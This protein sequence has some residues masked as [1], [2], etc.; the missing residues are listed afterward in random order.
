MTE[1]EAYLYDAET[2]LRR[3]RRT[4]C[5]DEENRG[6][7][8]QNVADPICQAGRSVEWRVEPCTDRPTAPARASHN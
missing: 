4:G 2:E 3:A 6:R 7:Q 8:G 1:E 5:P